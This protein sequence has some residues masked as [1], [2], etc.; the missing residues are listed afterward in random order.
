VKCCLPFAVNKDFHWQD[1]FS[2]MFMLTFGVRQ[3]SV[4]SPY[5]FAVYLELR[6]SLQII[7]IFLYAD[8]I[9]CISPSVCALETLLRARER[10][11]IW[12]GTSI[13]INKKL[14]YRLETGRQQCISL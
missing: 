3:G 12:L 14:S 13:N 7:Y 6:R 1:V 10:E 4:L 2:S 8:N 11:L 5:L 9:L